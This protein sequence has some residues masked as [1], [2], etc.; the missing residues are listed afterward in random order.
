MPVAGPDFSLA[1]ATNGY[2]W[3]YVDALSDDGQHGL[4]IIAFIGSVF[5]PYYARARRLGAAI[6]PIIVRSTSRSMAGWGNTGP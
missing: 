6:R 2:A 5:S 4:T 3:W 1:V